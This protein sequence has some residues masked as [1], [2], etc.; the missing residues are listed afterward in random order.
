[1]H[2]DVDDGVKSVTHCIKAGYMTHFWV[3]SRNP[4][5]ASI[6]VHVNIDNMGRTIREGGGDDVQVP[7]K[8]CNCG[9]F[10]TVFPDSGIGIVDCTGYT[11]NFLVSIKH[12]SRRDLCLRFESCSGQL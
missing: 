4:P 10:L 7:V 11:V 5:C 12:I 1:V 3:H 2:S 8:S 9:G 6:V